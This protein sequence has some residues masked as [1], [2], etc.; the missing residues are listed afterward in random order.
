M[1]INC[2]YSASSY[3]K[4]F[5]YIPASTQDKLPNPDPS[6]FKIIKSLVGGDLLSSR[7]FLIL[8]VNYPDCKNYEGN[9]ILVYENVTLEELLKQKTLDPHFSNSKEFYSPIARFEPTRKGWEMARTF[10]TAYINYKRI[11]L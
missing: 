2:F 5:A 9:K 10:V 3:D 4:N 8:K 1:G 6:N 7:K 11:M